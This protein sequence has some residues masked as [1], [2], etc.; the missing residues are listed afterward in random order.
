MPTHYIDCC[1]YSHN[2]ERSLPFSTYVP[3]FLRLNLIEVLSILEL[4]QHRR[5][6]GCVIYRVEWHIRGRTTIGRPRSLTSACTAHL[7][8]NGYCCFHAKGDLGEECRSLIRVIVIVQIPLVSA[9]GPTC[10]GIGITTAWTA[11]LSSLLWAKMSW[12]LS[13]EMARVSWRREL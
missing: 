2:H 5:F 12:G 10:T 13:S 8:A 9:T 11:W 7:Y 6:V 4:K 1:V 3:W